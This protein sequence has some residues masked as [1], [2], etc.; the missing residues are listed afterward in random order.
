M[1]AAPCKFHEGKVCPHRFRPL[2]RSCRAQL[3]I[4]AI[5]IEDPGL[6]VVMQT[7]V[8]DFPQPLFWTGCGHRRHHFYPPGEIAEHPVGRAQVKFA[9]EGRFVARSE[10][11]DARVL[12]KAADD[13]MHAN[14]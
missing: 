6:T 11:E 14:A 5:A 3:S 9:I 10:I 2:A 12:E 8:E 1:R 13:G 4:T 7:D